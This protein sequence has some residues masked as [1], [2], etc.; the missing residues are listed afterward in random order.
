MILF[1]QATVEATQMVKSKSMEVV[2]AVSGDINEVPTYLGV[3]SGQNRGIY[4][5]KC[6]DGGKGDC[7]WGGK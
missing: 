1:V 5:V 4:Y 2:Q 7:H 3:G 6:C